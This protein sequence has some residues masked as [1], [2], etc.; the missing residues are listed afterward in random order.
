MC[1]R[2]KWSMRTIC[3]ANEGDAITLLGGGMV[4]FLLRFVESSEDGK[5]KRVE[6]GW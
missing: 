5:E 6:L 1:R 2:L 3:T 4:P